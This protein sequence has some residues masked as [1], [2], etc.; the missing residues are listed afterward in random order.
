VTVVETPAGISVDWITPPFD[1]VRV[2][3]VEFVVTD[4]AAAREFYVDLLGLV[5]TAETAGALY[6]RGLEERLHHSIVLRSGPEP[7]VDHV[8]FRV[9]RPEDLPLV[10][11]AFEALGCPAHTVEGVE[12][13]QG[14]AV[15]VHDPLGFPLEFFHE[16][17]HAECLL[18]RFDLYRGAR[19]TRADH[20]NL[21]VPDAAVAYEQYRRLGFRCSE[22][23]A[24]DS[25]DRLVAAWL[26]RKP[27]VHD[28]AL[29]TGRGP[30]VHH[31]AFTTAE[32]AS[33]TGLCDMLAGARRESVIER[34]PGRHGV[35]NAFF[36]YLRDP[37]GHRIELYTGDYYTGDPDHRPIRWSVT[38]ARR[39]TFWGHHVPDSFFEEGSLVRGPDGRAVELAEPVLDERLVAVE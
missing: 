17:E 10:A 14:P 24:S 9:R 27:T 26:Y 30:R 38:D 19:I 2:A 23:I 22:Y 29:T 33:V 35:S 13:G 39:R 16:M 31:L 12:L 6:L 7:I 5:P 32:A 18:Q 37:D 4:L 25:D 1:I 15:R 28:V 3:H 8:A 34:G 21:Y 11:S 20:V 36:V